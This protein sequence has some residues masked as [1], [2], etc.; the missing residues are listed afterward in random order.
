[1]FETTD[2]SVSVEGENG[3]SRETRVEELAT[4]AI[5]A[6]AALTAMAYSVN[7]DT[8]SPTLDSEKMTDEAKPRGKRDSKPAGDEEDARNQPKQKKPNIPTI[9]ISFQPPQQDQATHFSIH[10]NKADSD[11]ERSQESTPGR[12]GQPTTPRG[13][14]RT[15]KSSPRQPRVTN[16]LKVD[17]S[18]RTQIA[19]QDLKME[20]SRAMMEEAKRQI[21]EAETKKEMAEEDL[22]KEKEQR[23]TEVEGL[24][25]MLASEHEKQTD[26]K[27]KYKTWEREASELKNQLDRA[28]QEFNALRANSEQRYTPDQVL[29]VMLEQQNSA[30]AHNLATRQEVLKAVAR[31]NVLESEMSEQ[32]LIM[33]EIKEFKGAVEEKALNYE[34]AAYFY[35]TRCQ[36]AHRMIHE[37]EQQ[38][39]ITKEQLKRSEDANQVVANHISQAIE[40][41]KIQRTECQ[42]LKEMLIKSEQMNQG[43]HS[44]VGD[45]TQLYEKVIIA[46][47]ENTRLKEMLDLKTKE[48]ADVKTEISAIRAAARCQPG[49]IET[50]VAQKE[51]QCRQ[52]MKEREEKWS[53]MLETQRLEL[54][55]TTQYSNQMQARALELNAELQGLRKQKEG[56]YEEF[57]KAKAESKQQAAEK[58]REV[59][60]IRAHAQ[61]MIAS[62]GTQGEAKPDPL[63]EAEKRQWQD[64][65]AKLLGDV[66][67]MQQENEKLKKQIE[68][69]KSVRKGH[70]H[71]DYQVLYENLKKS[72]DGIAS[73]CATK[74][75]E[76]REENATLQQKIE[77]VQD[78][79]ERLIQKM[80]NENYDN[81]MLLE[82]WDAWW[83][84]HKT[85]FESE[86][87]TDEEESD[88][89][90][91]A[92]ETEEDETLRKEKEYVEKM[93]KELKE[94]NK[95]GKEKEKEKPEKAKKVKV[96]ET[97]EEDVKKEEPTKPQTP[98]DLMAQVTN[99]LAQ[100]MAGM[101]TKTGSDS[102]TPVPK[103]FELPTEK[104]TLMTINSYLYKLGV[105]MSAASTNTDGTE[106]AWANEILTK[107][108]DELAQNLCEEKHKKLDQVLAKT[109]YKAL[110]RVLKPKYDDKCIELQKKGE[111]MGGRQTMKIWIESLKT[112]RNMT[113]M[114][115]YDRIKKMQWKGDSVQ[116]IVDFWWEW[117]ALKDSQ[118]T[119]VTTKDI[120][121]L[122]LKKMSNSST[123][124]DDLGAYQRAKD[125]S[126]IEN[127][128]ED[129]S[130]EFLERCLQRVVIKQET[131]AADYPDAKKEWGKNKNGKGSGKYGKGRRY[132][133]PYAAMPEEGG[134]GKGGKPK[135]GTKGGKNNGGAK[136][137]KKSKTAEE[138]LGYC[139]YYIQGNCKN[140]KNCPVSHQ[141]D[142][143]EKDKQRVLPPHL[144]SRSASREP[145]AKAPGGASKPSR[146]ALK[147]GTQ[148]KVGKDG[149]PECVCCYKW[150]SE[151]KCDAKTRTG[152][153]CKWPHHNEAKKKELDER[154][155]KEIGN[156]F[157]APEKGKGGGKGSGKGGGGKAKGK[158]VK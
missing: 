89:E 29:Q 77:E 31:G 94:A 61:R 111:M 76:I 5:A 102:K 138:L 148:W 10:S 152:S 44:I 35:E 96:D 20:E 2:T 84:D 139:F 109:A 124:K 135:G 53:Q 122:L 85:D 9:P 71:R 100:A 6:G 83:E 81:K 3:G 62:A 90:E 70:E 13:V 63:Q 101:A 54:V 119:K 106:M 60:E 140:G 127:P 57:V 75:K 112:E 16:L 23:Q 150:L 69:M 105:N 130:V 50:A 37:N 132:S 146:G 104:L 103:G 43:Q 34:K 40:V 73:Q 11:D 17:D 4:I 65:K 58:D 128:H 1:M 49:Q 56:I 87:E 78:D 12:K 93:E 7:D 8:G 126:T 142:L 107:S 38:A 28:S 45:T 66:M 59:E 48:N 68:E 129:Y 151:G 157:S 149:K 47:E 133:E 125:K 88:E 99:T 86:K 108:I 155:R 74:V 113:E 137:G 25:K 41:D 141:N 92:E 145:G 98:M 156:N 64:E 143:S 117:K 121:E 91:D 134:K 154:V 158:G 67:S 55:E 52:E 116:N 82:E 79:R 114:A 72:T 80:T 147:D 120:Q 32:K 15:P 131:D 14:R 144:R 136:D 118:G 27:K 95:D 97:K 42:Q 22:R 24:K 18:P 26:Y 123:F 36:D 33:N 39:M 46:T 110:P 51:S 21:K 115:A 19:N 153:E 30:E